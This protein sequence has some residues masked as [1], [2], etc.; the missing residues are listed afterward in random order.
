M[1]LLQFWAQVRPIDIATA[2]GIDARNS[3][4]A[5]ATMAERLKELWEVLQ[6]LGYE[7]WVLEDD[8]ST[9]L[10][11]AAFE[12]GNAFP[13]P[14]ECQEVTLRLQGHIEE[15]E[16]LK[17]AKPWRSQMIVIRYEAD[18]TIVKMTFNQT[19]IHV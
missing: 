16:A 17:I 15:A 11:I 3:T 7:A 6:Y 19:E 2:R 14:T 12:R 1:K 5:K 9:A 10:Q 4:K 8:Y 13:I 18:E